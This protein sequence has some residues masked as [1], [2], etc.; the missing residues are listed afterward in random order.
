PPHEYE[1]DQATL[2]AIEDQLPR[3]WFHCVKTQ[4]H[5]DRCDFQKDTKP[6]SC[7]HAAACETARVDHHERKNDQCLA[8]DDPV[9]QAHHFTLRAPKLWRLRINIFENHAV[10]QPTPEEQKNVCGDKCEDES[11]H[12]LRHRGRSVTNVTCDGPG[13]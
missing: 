5:T 12:A 10:E 1:L 9:K 13:L 8:D 2:A 4:A 3:K 6:N 11:L 7:D